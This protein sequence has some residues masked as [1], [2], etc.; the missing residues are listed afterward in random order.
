[1]A[2]CKKLILVS[3]E[4]TRGPLCKLMR[5]VHEGQKDGHGYDYQYH[6][7]MIQYAE[8]ILKFFRAETE[9]KVGAELEE[10]RDT[11]RD[12]GIL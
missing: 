4:K 2:A 8:L 11:L 12:K 9:L 1:M 6:R 7:L 3:P 5:E 10:I